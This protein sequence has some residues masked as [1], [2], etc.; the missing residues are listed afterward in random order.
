MIEGE[1]SAGHAL[2]P[3]PAS[4]ALRVAAALGVHEAGRVL[5]DFTI[6]LPTQLIPALAGFLVLP[7]LA[8]KLTPTELGVLTL[9]Q[10][11]ITLGWVMVA[12]WLASAIIRELP[13]HRKGGTVTAFSGALTRALG[14]SSVVLAA[15]AALLAAVGMASSAVSDNLFLIIA[16]ITGLTLQNVAVSLLAASLRP[17][18][19]VLV[20][21]TARTGGVLLGVVL[22]FQGHNVQGYLLGLALASL[23]VGSLGLALSWP[24]SGHDTPHATPASLGPWLRFGVPGSIAAV[25]T[26]GL[27]YL[28][29]YLLAALRDT[30]EVGIYSV[31]NV[32]GDKAVAI[33]A[34]AFLTAAGPLLITAYERS[35]RVEVERLMR[36]YTRVIL[37]VSLPIIGFVT[38]TAGTV[39]PLLAGERF[40]A[41]AA[42]VAPIISAGSLVYALALIGYTGLIV[43]KR[44]WPMVW[45]G[46]IG[47]LVNVVANLLLIPPFGIVGA[48]IATP[49]AMAAFLVG[50]QVWSSRH[51]TWHFPVMTLARAGIAAAAAYGAARLAL[52]SLDWPRGGELAFAAATISAVYL[53]SLAL[54]GELRHAST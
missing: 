22:V 21:A 4:L 39:V 3:A 20:D 1:H 23:V 30:G 2:P 32:I 40:Y 38:A 11:L 12:S 34:M 35:G 24:H 45:G 31:G 26:W 28:D 44:T 15:V 48:A 7:I 8:R 53:A 43:G 47:V 52:T 49:L 33:P 27:S 16:A 13:A 25:A 46:A 6:Y 36:A 29:R 41:K 9:A 50:T 18:A 5:R 54:L 37:L 51:A 17:R 42:D 14:L 10:T 19:Y